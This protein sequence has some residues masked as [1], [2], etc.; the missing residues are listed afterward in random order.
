MV[1]PLKT[2]GLDEINSLQ[3]RL[4]RLW[5][6]GRISRED[7]DYLEE[8]LGDCEKRIIEMK[9]KMPPGSRKTTF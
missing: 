1:A 2:K 6:L 5:G 4:R 9:E 3:A 8:R 7:F